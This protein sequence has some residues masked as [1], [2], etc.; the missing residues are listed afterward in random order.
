MEKQMNTIPLNKKTEGNGGKEQLKKYNN[1][2]CNLALL[3]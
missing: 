2:Q 1:G 3:A